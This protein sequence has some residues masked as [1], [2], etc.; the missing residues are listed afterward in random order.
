MCVEHDAK[1]GGC[2]CCLNHPPGLRLLRPIMCVDPFLPHTTNSYT[3]THVNMHL[4][5]RTYTPTWAEVAAAQCATRAPL[6]V[7]LQ[8]NTQES[9]MQTT[10]KMISPHKKADDCLASQQQQLL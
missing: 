7:D 10:H 4:H 9:R 2:C 5:R 6:Q 3:H 8:G 1:H